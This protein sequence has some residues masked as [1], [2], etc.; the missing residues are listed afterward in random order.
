MVLGCGWEGAAVLLGQEAATCS[1]QRE[2]RRAVA[3]ERE[4]GVER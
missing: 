2:E 1:T 4:R 3:G